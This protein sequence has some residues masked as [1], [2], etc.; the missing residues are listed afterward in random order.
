MSVF[1]P[2]QKGESNRATRDTTITTTTTII[3]TAKTII[4]T[5]VKI[6]PY[7]ILPKRWKQKKSKEI[8]CPFSLDHKDVL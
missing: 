4:T 6:L 2:F 7:P 5:T 3:T 8:K 1:I